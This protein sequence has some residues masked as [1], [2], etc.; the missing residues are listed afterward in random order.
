MPTANFSTVNRGQVELLI[1]IKN[2]QYAGFSLD[3]DSLVGVGTLDIEKSVDNGVNW[4]NLGSYT[5]T[6]YGVFLMSE[7][8]LVRCICPTLTEGTILASLWIASSASGTIRKVPF[9]VDY[10]YN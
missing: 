9:T 10:S 5:I 1:E 2:K 6:S 7:D 4:T 3:F 8:C